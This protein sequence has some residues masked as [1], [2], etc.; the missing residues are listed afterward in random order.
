MKRNLSQFEIEILELTPEG[1][2]YLEYNEK[3]GGNPFGYSIGMPDFEIEEKYGGIEG[4]YDECIK[5]KVTWEKLLDT[6]G[7]YDE[8]PEE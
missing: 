3:V 8:L 5:R 1:R 4:L 7:K 6:D 2:K